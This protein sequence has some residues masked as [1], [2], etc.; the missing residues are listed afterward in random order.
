M[1][2]RM[3]LTADRVLELSAAAGLAVVVGR[4]V[5]LADIGIFAETV[6]GIAVQTEAPV[7]SMAQL[8]VGKTPAVAAAAL[9]AVPWMAPAHTG[10]LRA[11]SRPRSA[12]QARQDFCCDSTAIVRAVGVVDIGGEVTAEVMRVLEAGRSDRADVVVEYMLAR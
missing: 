10:C 7:A 8:V 1:L 9:A 5:G 3:G 4:T 6:A 11:W 12:R 2:H